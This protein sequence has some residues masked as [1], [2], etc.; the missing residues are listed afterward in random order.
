MR[1]F[2]LLGFVSNDLRGAVVGE[3]ED[4]DIHLR[5]PR[6]D[7]DHDSTTAAE[8][9]Q[10]AHRETYVVQTSHGGLFIQEAHGLVPDGRGEEDHVRLW[11]VEG[12]RRPTL[13]LKEVN[14]HI[15]YI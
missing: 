1:L 15:T 6:G 5:S 14:E 4:G 3:R 7:V 10:A 2:E 11:D 12:L 9:G 8:V 13:K